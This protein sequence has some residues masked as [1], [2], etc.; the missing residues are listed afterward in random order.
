M[1]YLQILWDLIPIFD[2]FEPS[3]IDYARGLIDR[4]YQDNQTRGIIASRSLISR[5]KICQTC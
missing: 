3:K 1:V 4:L 5:L 2:V